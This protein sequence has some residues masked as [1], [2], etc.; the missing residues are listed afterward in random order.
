MNNI[1]AQWTPAHL[2]G[3]RSVVA[4]RT[5]GDAVITYEAYELKSE[6]TGVHAKVYVRVN[7]VTADWDRMNIEKS[8]DRVRLAGKAHRQFG[9]SLGEE[10][11]KAYVETDLGVFCEAAWSVWLSQY[12]PEV[13]EGDVERRA[14][15]LLIDPYVIEGGGTI[16]FAPPGKGKSYT[17]LLA[18][19]SVN[20][21]INQIFDVPK[22]APTVYINI[23]RSRESMRQRL[24]NV[25]EALGLD[26]N[27]PMAFVNARGRSLSDIY[28]SVA[29]FI[30]REGIEFVVLDSISR[31]GFMGSLVEDTT[32]NRITDALNGLC[33]TWL[34]LGHTS[35]VDE[36]HL[37]GSVHFDAAADVMVTLNSQ[38]KPTGDMGIG[39][40]ITKDND[41]GAR[42]QQI[43]G[44]SF[45]AKGLRGAWRARDSEF[46][47]V[48][49]GKPES[50]EDQVRDYLA[51]V[52]WATAADVAA[53]I[54]RHRTNVSH[55]LAGDADKYVRKVDGKR[56]MYSLRSRW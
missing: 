53:N 7:G 13:M 42:P 29:G 55:L 32:G 2:N 26:R 21:G 28:D 45:D 56:V 22:V 43:I 4:S 10:W 34:A 31:A 20:F 51:L 3:N 40:A 38:Q 52:G 8:E 18:A 19:Q 54:G 12:E 44:L 6:R 41:L 36:T 27:T 9:K 14:P 15:S 49:A 16:L 11:P 5:C 25:N 1:S 39:L 50:V 48:A 46:P 24:G 23:E 35:R 37:Y 47:T 17:A 33:K 30:A